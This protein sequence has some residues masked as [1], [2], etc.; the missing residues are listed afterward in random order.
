MVTSSSSN[1]VWSLN[2]GRNRCMLCFSNECL[3]R[4]YQKEVEPTT[5]FF[6]YF[7]HYFGPI[8]IKIVA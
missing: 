5:N 8:L 2:I 7:E 1:D 4:K 6:F 3:Q